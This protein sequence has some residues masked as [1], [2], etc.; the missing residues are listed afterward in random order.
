M[1]SLDTLRA[2][3]DTI[4]ADLFAAFSRR[5]EAADAIADAKH[6][7]GLPVADPGRERSKLNTLSTT[8]PAA[9]RDDAVVLWELLFEL[10]RARQYRRLAS[11]PS[12][13]AASI[14]DALSRTPALFPSDAPVAC[15][16]VEGAY[17]QI[18][19][20]RL[21]RHPNILYF[22]SFDAVFSAV[23]K[24]LC[25]YGVVPLEN[26]TAGSVNGVHDLMAA[27][28]F[29]IVRS[30][31]LKVDQHL[32]GVPGATLGGIREIRS[33]EQAFAQCADF[34]QS[35]LPDARL[36]PDVNT[37]AAARAVAA[38]GDP[39]VAAIA[40]ASCGRLYGLDCLRPSIQSR[41]NNRTRFACISRDLEIYPGADRASLMAVLP[42][43][44]GALYRLLSR[45][46]ALDVNLVKLESRPIPD[47]DFEFMFYFDLEIPAQDPR[48]LAL[49]DSLPS[50]CDSFAFF[51]AYSEIA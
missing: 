16:G 4:D 25:R 49:L 33:H 20:E 26:S 28:R 9:L 34:L 50:V 8:A 48:F 7:A 1:T 45:F 21:F 31:R 6:A 38:A 43:K 40:S 13:L 10:S 44:P 36:V 30:V 35:A 2:R 12:P 17:S 37:A 18:A 32:F 22:R 15:Q 23:G 24:G 3:I 27:H 5:M 39:S 41:G 14:S 11:S 19:A 29:S 47:R 42:H 51:G 46:N